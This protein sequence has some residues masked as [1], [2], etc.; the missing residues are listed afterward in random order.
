MTALN[1]CIATIRAA[2]DNALSDQQIEELMMELD[3]RRQA[4]RA[5]NAALSDEELLSQVAEELTSEVAMA[6][7]IER[8]NRALNI[9]VEK[10]ADEVIRA[11]PDA[12][13]GVKAL[14]S[15]AVRP[16]TGARDSVDS[17]AGALVSQY[18]GRAIAELKREGLLDIVQK[19]TREFQL[20]VARELRALS[21]ARS[22]VTKSAQARRVAEIWRSVTEEAR[23]RANRAGAWI[24]TRTDRIASQSHDPGRLLPVGKTVDEAF[25]EWREEILP[26]L[27][28]AESFRGKD[29][30]GF[31][32]AAFDEITRNE[33]MAVASR[34]DADT[35]EAVGRD[36]HDIAFSGPANLAKKLSR[37]RQFV[38]KSADD[39]FAYN[40]R[41]GRRS[42]FETMVA[43][44]E[45]LS[46]ATAL[47][48]KLGPNPRAMYEKLKR[49]Y[50]LDDG[51]D[52]TMDQLDGTA[53]MT[54]YPRAADISAAIVAVENMSKLGESVV[55]AFS[56]LSM[57]ASELSYQGEPLHMALWNSLGAP[58]FRLTSTEQVQ[59]LA[60][61]LVPG[62]S[63]FTAHL[64]GR[65]GSGESI[66]GRVAAA[67]RVFFKINLFQ[68]WTDAI[69]R[70]MAVMMARRMGQET[71]K[72]FSALSDEY[73]RV[74]DMYGIGEREWSVLASARTRL[75]DGREYITPDSIRA[76]DD[77]AMAPLT[78]ERIAAIRAEI[79]DARNKAQANAQSKD[80]L[81]S[82]QAQERLRTL[83]AE[84][85]RRINA[86]RRKAADALEN[87]YRTM[88]ND[89]I[90]IGVPH[91]GAHERA[92]LMQRLDRG[93]AA[94]IALRLF[95]QFK[96]FPL[97]MSTKVLARERFG[98]EDVVSASLGI[99][100]LIAG[101]TVMGLL[102]MAAK[103]ILAGRDPRNPFGEDAA[104]VWV[105]AA[106]QGGALSIYGDVLLNDLNEYNRTILGALAGPAY[107]DVENLIKLAQGV[108][109][110]G[111]ISPQNVRDIKNMLPYQNWFM[112]KAAMDYL[113]VQNIQE[114]LDPGYVERYNR[115]L[116]DYG[117]EL[118]WLGEA[119]SL[120]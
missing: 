35:N 88:I 53:W 83:S 56:D 108:A 3:R 34:A 109:T 39:W 70:S 116:R 16:F 78:G 26:R 41:Y 29:Q 24:G 64:G 55:T 6:T 93:S 91:P 13:R 5:Q 74:L 30:E 7:H 106:L 23:L 22:Q 17:R 73:R 10:R 25:A 81:V 89:R 120:Q 15:G 69:Q 94:G 110:T 92:I 79:A 119:L 11:A 60:D 9:I 72:A 49:K 87:A 52:K 46:R 71:A 19:P 90:N 82:D 67:Q 98:H 12:K 80:P 21:E 104:A 86:V 57:M 114:M 100:R 36:L 103:S 32:R 40:E 2:S 66:T 102:S 101:T 95:M 65:F 107:G 54:Q 44:I 43:D 20:D 18:L 96:S 58:F 97:T 76:L 112:T 117:Y 37:H 68:P 31:L 111:Q 8:R 28:A 63:D 118:N 59:E 50:A 47:M 99:A 105:K 61:L 14:L 85:E 113:V 4:R 84:E 115:R 33:H 38:F 27:D 48:E 51:F 77:T 42:L 75:D 1:D 45:R 62:V